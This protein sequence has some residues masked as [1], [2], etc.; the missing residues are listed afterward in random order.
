MRRLPEWLLFL[1]FS[2]LLILPILIAKYLDP[3]GEEIAST[4]KVWIIIII[5]A[6]LILFMRNRQSV[7]KFATYLENVRR[8]KKLRWLIILL[9][10]QITFAT[11]CYHIYS[12]NPKVYV[13]GDEIEQRRIEIARANNENESQ[14]VK[15]FDTKIN[16][17]L[18]FLKYLEKN[19][20]SFIKSSD[21]NIY[22][23]D[24][25]CI[26]FEYPFDPPGGGSTSSMILHVYTKKSLNHIKTIHLRREEIDIALQ[27]EIGRL[28]RRASLITN[29]LEE[30]KSQSNDF[31]W[32][33]FQF[34]NYY[35]KEQ[36]Q[37]MSTFL[38]VMDNLKLLLWVPITILISSSFWK[39]SDNGK[40]D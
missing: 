35:F 29:H 27:M 39:R 21:G 32:T 20:G 12:N 38:M 28:E 8:N 1:I 3:Y 15:D 37:A 13:L 24:S 4:L 9:T 10:M 17:E 34:L 6:A 14:Y 25:L 22:T 2:F 40:V 19:L 18:T 16:D 36:L 30:I 23:N 26:V 31:R 11:I 33:Y 5:P 7:E